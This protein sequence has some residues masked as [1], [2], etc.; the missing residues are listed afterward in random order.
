MGEF[1]NVAT[2]FKSG[3]T[4][5]TMGRKGGSATS[6]KKRLVAT[7]REMKKFGMKKES[8]IKAIKLIESPELS[9]VD[10]FKTL[11]ELEALAE[12][13]P[14]IKSLVM[15]RKLDWIKTVHGEKKRV[16]NVHHVITWDNEMKNEIIGRLLEEE[17]TS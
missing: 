15:Q 8:V 4:A 12:D 13:D 1:P 17:D 9:Y 2:Q 6:D 7:I 10:A 14:K 3:T 16:E 11:H 5:V